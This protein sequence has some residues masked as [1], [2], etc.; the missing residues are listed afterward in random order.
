MLCFLLHSFMVGDFLF[1]LSFHCSHHFGVNFFH[2]SFLKKLTLCSFRCRFILLPSPPSTEWE[3]KK[4][5]QSPF[6]SLLAPPSL[7]CISFPFCVLFAEEDHISFL[8]HWLFASI[9]CFLQFLLFLFGSLSFFTPLAPHGHEGGGKNEKRETR[10]GSR[11]RRL[12][13][14]RKMIMSKRGDR[15][16]RKGIVGERKKNGVIGSVEKEILKWRKGEKEKNKNQR[17]TQNRKT[18][19]RMETRSRRW[20]KRREDELDLVQGSSANSWLQQ[21]TFFIT[22]GES[23][24]ADWESQSNRATPII[25]SLTLPSVSWNNAVPQR[26]TRIAVEKA[27]NHESSSQNWWGEWS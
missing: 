6:S 11:S 14:E 15:K 20:K 3:G 18:Q 2:T 25:H 22:I 16:Q 21:I 1:L 9:I 10:K 19:R 24:M 7:L 27:K 8:L 23:L 4:S 13:E 5:S 12:G 17:R 26:H